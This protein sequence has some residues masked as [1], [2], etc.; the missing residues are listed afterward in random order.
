MALLT[1]S[2]LA[3]EHG[4]QHSLSDAG[5]LSPYNCL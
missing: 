1:K 4:T 3:I 5:Q 2:V